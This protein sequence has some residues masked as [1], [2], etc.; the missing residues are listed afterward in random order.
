MAY[1]LQPHGLQSV[2]LLVRGVLQAGAL[3]RA[4]VPSPRGSLG[5]RDQTRVF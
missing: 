2:R 1:L 4:A 3:E 5:P